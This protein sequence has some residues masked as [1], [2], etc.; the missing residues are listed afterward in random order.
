MQTSS[1]SYQNSNSYT[2]NQNILILDVLNIR[3]ELLDIRKYQHQFK[4]NIKARISE[5]NGVTWI[6]QLQKFYN[7]D[8]LLSK[9]KHTSTAREIL[10]L[11]I[12]YKYLKNGVEIIVTH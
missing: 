8:L 3:D 2:N 1:E 5:N 12:N 10:D 9:I 7:V 4:K 6:K 11:L